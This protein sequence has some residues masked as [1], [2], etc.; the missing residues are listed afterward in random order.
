M[1][2]YKSAQHGLVGCSSL[3][4]PGGSMYLCKFLSM[5]AGSPFRRSSPP[6]P[7]QTKAFDL[8]CVLGGLERPCTI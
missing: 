3:T 1:D 8:D 6:P 2:L 5:A 7:P 4:P